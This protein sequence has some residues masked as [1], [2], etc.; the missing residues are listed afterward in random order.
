MKIILLSPELWKIILEY[1]TSCD[2]YVMDTINSEETLEMGFRDNFVEEIEILKY[3][4]VNRMFRDIILELIT[5][6]RIPQDNIDS[7]SGKILSLV[8]SKPNTL[9]KIELYYPGDRIIKPSLLDPYI[10][11]QLSQ[12]NNLRELIMEQYSLLSI[13]DIKI[14]S[15]NYGYQLL[16]LTISMS[17][18]DGVLNYVA[19]LF[20]NLQ[21]LVLQQRSSD[22]FLFNDNSLL[23]N[24]N[25]DMSKFENLTELIDAGEL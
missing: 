8:L 19:D 7:R 11:E 13:N 17:L 3:R 20:P 24:V 10:F 6:I 25:V 5:S 16:S 21:T 4:P 15:L 2:I 1:V 22:Q 14:I 18:T 12:C 23:E 9:K